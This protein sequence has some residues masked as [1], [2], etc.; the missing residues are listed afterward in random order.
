M[1]IILLV[2]VSILFFALYF[3][4]RIHY[5]DSLL[6]KEKDVIDRFIRSRKRRIKKAGV[7][8]PIL[9]YLRL[10]F[11][12]PFI[13]GIIVF[14]LT[15]HALLSVIFGIVGF[16]TPELII[17]IMEQEQQRKFEERYARSLEQLSSSLRAGMSISQAVDD[18]ANCK[19]VHDTM[20]SKY[21]RLS[22]DLQMGLQ[23]R[24]AFQR[25]AEGTH[26]QDTEDVAMAIDIQNEVGGHEA[27]VIRDIASHI[28]ERILL[29]REVKSIFSGT[30]S[31]VWIMDVLT[32]ITFLLFAAVG[33]AYIAVYFSNPL[34]LMVMAV[35]IILPVIG[36]IINH[37]ILNTI[38]KGA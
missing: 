16:L 24:D 11:V 33:N 29:R 12:C 25:F 18:V 6:S 9:L 5:T 28:Q 37:K 8:F 34:F 30:S 35:L 3:I 13:I 20:R 7:H 21:A 10:M 2:I 26:N 17:T 1:H 31:M 27:E 23:I 38:K 14:L 19:F 36:S 32:P 22:A 15:G 4:V